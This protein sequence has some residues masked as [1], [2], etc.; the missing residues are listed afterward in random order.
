MTQRIRTAAAFVA[1]IDA[2]ELA[3]RL[4]QIG[5]GMRAPPGTNATKA[6]DT[7]ERNWPLP[8]ASGGFPFRRMARS[9][10]EYF[11]ECIDKGQQPS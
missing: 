9:S 2:E 7:A 8:D 3:F 4:M 6:L 5:I 10:I 11:R 1:E